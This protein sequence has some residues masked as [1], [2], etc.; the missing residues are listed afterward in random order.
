MEDSAEIRGT[1]CLTLGYMRGLCEMDVLNKT[2][3]ALQNEA[4]CLVTELTRS[5]LNH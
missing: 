5:R 3:H 4:A 1:Q 2:P